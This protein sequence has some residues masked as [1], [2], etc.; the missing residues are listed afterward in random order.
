[1][2]TATRGSDL[3]LNAVRYASGQTEA[4][5]EPASNV[6]I[7][8]L[9]LVYFPDLAPLLD[10][11]DGDMLKIV[12]EMTA[13]LRKDNAYLDGDKVKNAMVVNAL[14][15]SQRAKKFS[16][17]LRPRLKDEVEKLW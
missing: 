4:K 3:S 12:E 8:A 1:M 2:T 14:K 16:D 6:K 7:S 10:A 15:S 5:L 17:D 11:F 13:E 9:L